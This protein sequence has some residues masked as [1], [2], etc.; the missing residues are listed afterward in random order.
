MRPQPCDGSPPSPQAPGHTRSV[1]WAPSHTPT[2]TL[3]CALVWARPGVEPLKP[4][5]SD[6]LV[7]AWEVV[8]VSEEEGR[9]SGN[10]VSSA[11]CKCD[12]LHVVAE[13]WTTQGLGM[14]QKAQAGQGLRW[15]G[16][17]CPAQRCAPQKLC[18]DTT[19]GKP[20]T[21][22]MG[23]GPRTTSSRAL[24]AQK[25]FVSQDLSPVIC[26]LGTR[27]LVTDAVAR[28]RSL[29][30]ML[31]P[32]VTNFPRVL[33]SPAGMMPPCAHVLWTA[34]SFSLCLSVSHTLVGNPPSPASPRH[35]PVPD[36]EW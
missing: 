32:S 2:A 7:A 1:L 27:S 10:R 31:F 20:C 16:R 5:P 17:L 34:S 22:W 11:D 23:G 30:L 14:G 25:G 33:W 18:S 28:D 9:R 3:G 6:G 8:L 19:Q 13:Y 36:G 24:R 12:S 21:C 26:P 29:P 15:V 35:P 4:C